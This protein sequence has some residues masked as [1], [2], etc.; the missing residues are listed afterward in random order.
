MKIVTL[1]RI[2][3]KS[4]EDSV[5]TFRHI[6]STVSS[7]LLSR[8]KNPDDKTPTTVSDL[9]KGAE[10]SSK[11]SKFEGFEVGS[12]VLIT[13]TI[14]T[15]TVVDNVEHYQ[16]AIHDGAFSGFI[17]E[18]DTVVHQVN[19][20]KVVVAN[21][22]GVDSLSD[23][24]YREVLAETL[25]KIES[26]EKIHLSIIDIDKLKEELDILGCVLTAHTEDIDESTSSDIIDGFYFSPDIIDIYSTVAAL[27]QKNPKQHQTVLSIGPS[28]Y[29]KT[30][31]IR[32]FAN[33]MGIDCYILNCGFVTDP[34]EWFG[35]RQAEAGSTMFVKSKLIELIQRGDV[36]IGLDEYNR[37]AP[38]IKNS[39]YG[40][41]GQDGV[42]ELFGEEIRVG[43]NVVFIATVN[44]GAAYSG[45]FALDQAEMNR[46]RF[47]AQ[48][49]AMPFSKEVAVLV[50]K[51]E[52]EK[53]AAEKI[54]KIISE[55]RSIN[56]MD[57]GAFSTRTSLYLAEAVASGQNMRSAFQHIVVNRVRDDN[58]NAVKRSD[59]E[60]IVNKHLGVYISSVTSG[61]NPFERE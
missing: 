58:I 9:V 2:S 3:G 48:V 15:N 21:A 24:D 25:A 28:G 61:N 14:G 40:L 41:L 1:S 35:T 34:E 46:F 36:A 50:S 51:T 37:V 27:M 10:K 23:K 22:A 18:A 49:E 47:V 6:K 31:T 5:T 26:K 43:P 13:W 11:S 42:T 52:I 59:V 30:A 32:E 60:E 33:A 55:V 29:G 56:N 20:A 45:V 44:L 8:S 12:L 53:D 7:D 16:P 39:I 38:E 4:P 17:V 54:V 57:E 19:A